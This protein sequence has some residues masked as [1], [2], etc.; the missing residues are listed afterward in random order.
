MQAHYHLT[1]HNTSGCFISYT[2][3]RVYFVPKI[4][5]KLVKQMGYPDI[6]QL[7]Q[8]FTKMKYA[9][10]DFLFTSIN[11][12]YKECHSLFYLCRKCLYSGTQCI[13]S[14][15]KPEKIN[16][17]FFKTWQR[18]VRKDTTVS[19]LDAVSDVAV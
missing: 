3:H 6:R 9:A 4:N 2:V 11:S 14:K 16:G 18:K 19:L 1:D 8:I 5:K 12:I 10:L 13:S 7:P 15:I 17:C